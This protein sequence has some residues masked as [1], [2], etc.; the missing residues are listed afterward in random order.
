MAKKFINVFSAFIAVVLFVSITVFWFVRDVSF[1]KNCSSYLKRAAS[2]NSVETA[3]NE[4]D[5]ALAYL[6]ANNLTEGNSSMIVVY[7]SNDIG[8]WY[9]NLKDFS[10]EFETLTNASPL[11]QSNVLMK[12]H[13]SLIN[14]EENVKTPQDIEIFPYQKIFFILYLL[15]IAFSMVFCFTYY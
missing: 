1:D 15:I 10:N 11:E 5:K 13:E 8:Y 12:F 3:K 6:E 2:A 7:P 9:R 4:L 14:N